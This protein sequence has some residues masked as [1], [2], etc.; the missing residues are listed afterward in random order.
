MEKR[1]SNIELLRIILIFMVIL[2]HSLSSTI[3]KSVNSNVNYIGFV[4]LYVFDRPAVNVFILISA[5]F[6]WDKIEFNHGRIWKKC[7]ANCMLYSYYFI[8]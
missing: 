3:T 2:I 7:N 6:S 4:G 5:Y 1:S 8:V